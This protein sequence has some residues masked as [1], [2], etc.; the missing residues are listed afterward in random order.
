MGNRVFRITPRWAG[1]YWLEHL[2]AP[3]LV[4]SVSIILIAMWKAFNSSR[5]SSKHAYLAVFLGFFLATALAAH[6]AGARNLLQFIGVLCLATGA[7]FDEALGYK[8]RLIRFGSAA[9]MILAALNL[10]W[11][12]RSSSYTPILATDGYRA[13]LKENGELLA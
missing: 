6:I 7:L 8:P 2:D 12:S 3:I 4:F 10:I 11:L 1:A 9:I 5:F 13:F